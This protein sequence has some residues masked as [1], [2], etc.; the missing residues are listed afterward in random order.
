VILNETDASGVEGYGETDLRYARWV[1]AGELATPD[2]AIRAYFLRLATDTATQAE[3]RAVNRNLVAPAFRA[4]N[5]RFRRAFGQH[6]LVVPVEPQASGYGYLQAP[7]VI[8]PHIR[9]FLEE[10]AAREERRSQEAPPGHRRSTDSA[11]G[12]GSLSVSDDVSLAP[13]R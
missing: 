1:A 3:L 7:E 4:A 2:P 12:R 10:V 11:A 9:R 8:E 6:L 13:R 5:E